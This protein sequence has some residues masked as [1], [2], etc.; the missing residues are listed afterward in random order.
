MRHVLH[1]ALLLVPA[2]VCLS[3]QGVPDD[4]VDF[5][6]EGSPPTTE[7]RI[8][9]DGNVEVRQVTISAAAYELQKQRRTRAAS[10][11]AAGLTAIAVTHG[12][13]VCA[14][15]RSLWL[16]S[17]SDL[18]GARLCIL[19]SAGSSEALDYSRIVR[20]VLPGK[21][22]FWGGAVRSFWAGDDTGFFKQNSSSSTKE[23][24]DP[25]QVSGTVSSTVA[26][27]G[28]AAVSALLPR[29]LWFRW[30]FFISP[31][32]ACGGGNGK[33]IV[34]GGP[35]GFINIA[36]PQTLDPGDPYG[37]CAMSHNWTVNPGEAFNFAMSVSAM[38]G[39][40]A[41]AGSP[42]CRVSYGADGRF[43]FNDVYRG[44]LSGDAVDLKTCKPM[45]F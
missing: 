33:F 35:V 3:C 26:A 27:S 32:S 13:S 7:A 30:G 38:D 44:T 2:M 10:G 12:E 41:G 34:S 45:G 5:P 15:N 11:V 17:G 6:P 43:L 9:P 1:A 31:G 21:T 23:R 42:P 40:G 22:L 28:L 24:F 4:G 8:L 14:D 16:Y 18:S 20:L 29:D 36:H 39:S 37:H 25:W 19:R